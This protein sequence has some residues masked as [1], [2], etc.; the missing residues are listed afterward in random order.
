MKKTAKVKNERGAALIMTL[1]MLTIVM[2]LAGSAVAISQYA[3]RDSYTYA[4]INRSAYVAESAAYRI[5]WM[6]LNDRKK[7]PS[8]DIGGN[9]NNTGTENEE[10]YQADGRIRVFKGY[11]KNERDIKYRIIDAVNGLNISGYAPQRDLLNSLQNMPE[12]EAA[13]KRWKLEDFI[14]KIQDYVD[15]EDIPRLNSWEKSEYAQA[16]LI[17]LPRNRPLQYREELLLVPE[18]S[19]IC[20]PDKSGRLS[21]IRLIAPKGLPAIVGR[22]SLYSTPLNQI[23]DH[24]NLTVQDRNML[25]AAMSE[26][27][28]NG[29][30]L[31]DT[32]S[33]GL[34]QLLELYFGTSESSFYTVLI[35]TSAPMRP[36]IRLAV[37]FQLQFTSNLQI[38]FYEF[39]S[40]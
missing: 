24:C 23:M 39:M 20:T 9:D 27:L 13:A 40:Y 8:R 30:P 22:P 37:T 5:Y 38:Q 15:S 4:E 14:K 2:L 3:E 10:R 26:W 34:L 36:G 1:C 18:S 16:N 29:T 33:A 11:E 28:Q 25:S 35:D 21:S 17:N 12:N 31:K 19:L 32:L 7:F 6:L